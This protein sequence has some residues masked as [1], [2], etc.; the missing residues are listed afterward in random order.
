MIKSNPGARPQDPSE[1]SEKIRASMEW[2]FEQGWLQRGIVVL[3]RT[4]RFLVFGV[5]NIVY[6]ITTLSVTILLFTSLNQGEVDIVGTALLLALLI[7]FFG[8]NVFSRF[9]TPIPVDSAPW[10]YVPE[11]RKAELLYE[12][13][14]IDFEYDPSGFW[15]P[16]F[17]EIDMI[18]EEVESGKGLEEIQSEQVLSQDATSL[19]NRTGTPPDDDP[20]DNK[21]DS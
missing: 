20:N 3:T 4:S 8:S 15:D 7:F 5:C 21:S 19:D 1:L 10:I 11:F 16:I 13:D 6:L 18:Q 12:R 2:F 9:P 14:E 17:E